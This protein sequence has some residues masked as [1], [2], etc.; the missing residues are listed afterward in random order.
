MDLLLQSKIF[1]FIQIMFVAILC[2]MAY[3]ILLDQVTFTISDEY[4]TKFKFIRFGIGQLHMKEIMGAAEVRL[5][6]PRLGVV[7]IAVLASWWVGMLMGIILGVIGLFHS[8]SKEMYRIALKSIF[9][10]LAITI[11]VAIIGCAYGGL[12]V[13]DN[14]PDWP[15]PINLFDQ[16]SF[17]V[18]GCIHNFSYIGGGL[19][20]LVAIF[21]SLRSIRKASKTK[22]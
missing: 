15:F 22:K 11:L 8:N 9:I 3:G 6:Y 18:V 13:V 21:Y 4:F 1:R 17:I 10:I 19:G 2:S 14:P 5:Q 20:L 16:R 7:Q 12:Y